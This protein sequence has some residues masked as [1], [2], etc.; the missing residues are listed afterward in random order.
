MYLYVTCINVLLFIIDGNFH[1]YIYMCYIVYNI[2]IYYV[3]DIKSLT[4]VQG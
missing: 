3:Y 2:H 4:T 1:T